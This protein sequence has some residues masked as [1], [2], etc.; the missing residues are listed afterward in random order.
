MPVTVESIQRARLLIKRIASANNSSVNNND[1]FNP[2]KDHSV[3]SIA[4][5]P[6]SDFVTVHSLLDD[7]Y[8]TAAY[9]G[10][11]RPP[12][13]RM[14]SEN[15]L[16]ADMNELTR[17]IVFGDSP[18]STLQNQV[19][20]PPISTEELEKALTMSTVFSGVSEA[21]FY[22]YYLFAQ[23]YKFPETGWSKISGSNGLAN[24]EPRLSER[25]L[26][27]ILFLQKRG[28]N[29]SGAFNQWTHSFRSYGSDWM[30]E[31]FIKDINGPK[32]TT[33]R[34]A[35]PAYFYRKFTVGSLKGKHPQIT[36]H[37]FPGPG[38]II[39]GIHSKVFPDR[40]LQH[41]FG[42]GLQNSKM[43]EAINSRYRESL[44]GSEADLANTTFGFFRGFVLIYN[45]EKMKVNGIPHALVIFNDHFPH[46]HSK[47]AFL[48]N[49]NDT[50]RFL[51]DPYSALN[52]DNIM[53]PNV[54]SGALS[55]RVI[56]L[57]SLKAQ[58]GFCE[59]VKSGFDKNNRL[60]RLQVHDTV[61]AV[62]RFGFNQLDLIR[63][64]YRLHSL[65]YY[66]DNAYQNF[67]KDEFRLLKELLRINRF[68]AQSID[69]TSNAEYPVAFPFT[70]MDHSI[71]P[72]VVKDSGFVSSKMIPHTSKYPNGATQFFGDYLGKIDLSEIDR[73]TDDRIR[74]LL[75]ED[76]SLW[77]DFRESLEYNGGNPLI[78]DSSYRD[79]G[80]SIL[81]EQ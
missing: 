6:G 60:L 63:E 13:F 12:N 53:H 59:E 31:R 10:R 26:E 79:L 71:N 46:N 80:K 52:G 66:Y 21:E 68:I 81:K 39:N 8:H 64:S 33:K 34:S 30:F 67:Y 36:I 51:Q 45:K 17:M 77:F 43:Y 50:E 42:T 35:H 16:Q 54:L 14:G 47:T 25:I 65:G 24:M 73:L 7:L 27:E 23:K 3:Y 15:E 41:R 5:G 56:D 38:I 69:N 9:L 1:G 18:I 49:G 62:S 57:V 19:H 2:N 74:D 44:I 61:E 48:V 29:Y 78:V 11:Y 58:A 28:F 70:F 75:G 40:Y 32:A 72:A 37:D 76:A 4:Q 20:M 55:N 22:Y